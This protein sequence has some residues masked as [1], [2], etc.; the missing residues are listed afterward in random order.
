MHVDFTCEE[1]KNYSFSHLL[2]SFVFLF[3]FFYLKM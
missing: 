3:F 1:K 2:L